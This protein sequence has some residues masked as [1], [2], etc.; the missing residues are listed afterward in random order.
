MSSHDAQPPPPAP[1]GPGPTAAAEDLGALAD[2]L[3]RGLHRLANEAARVETLVGA[4]GGVDHVDGDV[5]LALDQAHSNAA[6][7][8]ATLGRA[9]FG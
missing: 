9:G 5:R 4:D 7:I 6:A 8:V 2:D 1:D 3:A